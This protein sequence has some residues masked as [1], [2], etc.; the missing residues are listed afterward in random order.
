MNRK[1]FSRRKLRNSYRVRKNDRGVRDILTVHRSNKH[2]YAQIVGLDGKVKVAVSSKGKL[3]SNKK[4]NKTGVE[5]AATVG[6]LVAQ[7]AKEIG[8]TGVV[9]NKGAYLYIGRVKSLAEAARQG[10]LDF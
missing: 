10:G 5:I 9:F 3:F 7:K 8:I 2:I 6:E 1:T 4:N